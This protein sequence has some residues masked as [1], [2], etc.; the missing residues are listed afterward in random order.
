M[1]NV[2]GESKMNEKTYTVVYERDG[3]M[4]TA[5]VPALDGCSTQGRTIAQTRERIREAISLFDDRAN[6]A[7]LEDDIRLPKNLASKLRK[8]LAEKK[9]IDA[10]SERVHAIILNTA[11]ADRR[12]RHKFR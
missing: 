8:V 9:K 12:Y 6:K 11:R 3:A 4:W 10:A 5:S 7:V 2:E 1:T